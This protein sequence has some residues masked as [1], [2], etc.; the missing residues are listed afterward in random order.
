MLLLTRD[1]SSGKV[2]YSYEAHEPNER[3]DVT[4]V[5]HSNKKKTSKPPYNIH[6]ITK[7]FTHLLD[8]IERKTIATELVVDYS[9]L[10]TDFIAFLGFPTG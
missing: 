3:N 7:S 1:K 9:G 5:P 8:N 10:E 4:Y 2:V 6:Q